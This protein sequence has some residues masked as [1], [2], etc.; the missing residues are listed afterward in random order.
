ME[1]LIEQNRPE[2]RAPVLLMAF[3]GW[4]DAAEVATGALRFLVRKWG[5]EECAEIEPEDFYVFT[6]TRPQVRIV[7]SAQRRITWPQNRFY[8]ARPPGS[9]RDFLI[10]IGTEPQLRWKT[11]TGLVL[12]YARSFDA[13]L[14][15]MLGGLLADVLHSRPP[16]LTG[17]I[18]D[19]ELA[20]RLAHLGLQRSRYEGP[21][22]ILGVFGDACR[23]RNLVSGSLWGNV[24]HYISSMSNPPITAALLRAVAELF[25]VSLDLGELD[26]SATRF[27]A[28]VSKAIADDAD[29]A[30]YVRRLEERERRALS[31]PRPPAELPAPAPE[32]PNAEQIVRELEEFLRRKGKADE[33]PD[34][35]S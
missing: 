12:D 13:N 34:P 11:F 18:G 10:L 20:P 22:G 26:R 17:A 23:V 1:N 30:A 35:T 3:A 5:A 24:P 15:L 4:N 19:P 21:T 32:L 14:V 33:D 8:H 29:V 31:A 9:D 27:N 6:E 7:D 25:D 16:V 2:L 28:Q